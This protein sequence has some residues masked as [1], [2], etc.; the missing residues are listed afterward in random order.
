MYE[1][2]AAFY[3]EIYHFKDYEA[4][5]RRLRGMIERYQRTQGDRLL[6]VACGTGKHL[7]C[8]GDG[9]TAT[10]IDLDPKMIEIASRRLPKV[11]FH[12]D[13]MVTFKLDQTYDV[14]LC[15]FS[16][17]GYV[18][19]SAR[20]QAAIRNMA[21][22]LAPGGV[23]IVEPWFSG[24]T[25]QGGTVHA[26]YVDKPDLKITRMNISTVEHGVS[27]MDFHYLIGTREEIEYLVERHELGLFEHDEYWAAFEAAGLD[28]VHDADGLTGRGL[29]IG[30][31][32]QA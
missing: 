17:I 2:T 14:I 29:Y 9:F 31:K 26:T 18:R 25:F 11:A 8:L 7:A 22:H 13:D 5:A 4:E 15:L 16:S 6:D 30:C 3:D 24:E 23:L 28:V 27:V 10:G 12:V 21:H 32:P 1:K 19:T 20:L